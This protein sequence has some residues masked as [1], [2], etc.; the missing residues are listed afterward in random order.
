[1]KKYT[2]VAKINFRYTTWIAY[3]VAGICAAAMIVDTI[4][5]KS[6]GMTGDNAISYYSM[7]YLICIMA[8]IFIASIN[9]SR[10]INIGVKKKAYFYGCAINYVVFAAI[11]SLCGVIETFLI[12]PYLTSD[13]YQ[14][15][16]LVKVFG[17]DS[18]VFTAFFS[19]FA[20][21][22]LVESVL[23]T[24]TFIQDKWY[25]WLAD[26]IVVVIIS[27]FTPIPALRQVETAFFNLIIFSA[28]VAQIFTCLLLA[29]AVYS[30]N[31]VYL[32]NKIS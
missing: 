5:D 14:I 8:P 30:T 20:F 7:L 3:L 16:G 15:Y 22:L 6:M 32:K 12:D 2:T 11:I 26:V 24:F 18:N 9:Y 29:A 1:M 31:L 13:G 23:H 25:G 10:H 28:P 17:W 4:I 21:L 27:V 19:Q